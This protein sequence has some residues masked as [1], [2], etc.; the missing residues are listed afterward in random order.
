MSTYKDKDIRV[1]RVSFNAKWVSWAHTGF[2]YA[3]F[4]SA[5]VVGISLHYHK[6]VQNQYYGYPDEWFP[7]VS[8]TIGDRYPERS[9]FMFFIAITSGPRFALVALWYTLTRRSGK[10]LPEFVAVTG[11]FR[12]LTCGGWTY[13]TSTDNH[14]W[15]DIFMISYL[16]ATIPWTAGC[17]TLSPPNAKAIKYRKY[18]A[19][20]FFTTI[21]PM[22]YFFVQ[23]KMHRVAG[24]SSSLPRDIFISN[25]FLAYTTYSF[26]E[27]SLILYDIAFDAVTALDF[28]AFEIIVQHVSTGYVR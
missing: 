22:V 5:F 18:I 25:P 9:F 3:A 28:D 19:T 24:G 14:Y 4:L 10:I 16:V 26:F 8:A 21:I 2:A 12:T 7:S 1:D 15:H 17:L 23:H 6:I 27:W 13:I 11:L 20:A